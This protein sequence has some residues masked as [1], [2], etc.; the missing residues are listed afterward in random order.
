[1]FH[2]TPHFLPDGQRLLFTGFMPGILRVGL[3][4]V[5]SSSRTTLIE[6]GAAPIYLASG[7]IAYARVDEGE[8]LVVPFDPESLQVGTPI[9]M[10]Q[11][12]ATSWGGRAQF[13]VS[14]NGHLA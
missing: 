14:Q 1:E 6:Q 11:N 7:H 13:D 4:D 8:L 5:E 2:R 3:F 10:L 9:P 12:I